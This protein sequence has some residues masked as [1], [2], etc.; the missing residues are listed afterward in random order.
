MLKDDD[1][2]RVNLYEILSKK[3]ITHNNT[4]NKFTD[5][6]RFLIENKN[7]TDIITYNS[8]NKF[9]LFNVSI[10]E[11]DNDGNPF[12]DYNYHRNS[13]IIDNINITASLKVKLSYIING[14][15]YLQNELD[16]FIF[17]T[18][19]YTEFKFRITFLETPTL[20]DHFNISMRNYVLDDDSL[21]ILRKDENTVITNKFIYRYGSA[22]HI[23]N[24]NTDR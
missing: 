19:R 22:I 8:K 17:T 11:I 18:S 20:N 1:K 9:L 16:E 23:K 15:E 14:I 4:I 21:K 24:I 3:R 2:T 6:L 13:D 5:G 12:Y 7:N 10:L